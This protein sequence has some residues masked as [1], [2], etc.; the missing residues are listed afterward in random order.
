M[1]I[2]KYT[3]CN[4]NKK[5]QNTKNKPQKVCIR[6]HRGNQKTLLNN[7]KEDLHKQR[8][9]KWIYYTELRAQKPSHIYNRMLHTQQSGTINQCGENNYLVDGVGKTNLPQERK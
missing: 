7:I 9:D 2:L 8:E 5:T 1:N 4:S 3:I 6:I